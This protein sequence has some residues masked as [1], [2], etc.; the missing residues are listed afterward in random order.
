V[1]SRTHADEPLILL[2]PPLL[3]LLVLSF[4]VNTQA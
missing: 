3:L 1:Y 2:L 4:V